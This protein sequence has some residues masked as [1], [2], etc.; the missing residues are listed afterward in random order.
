MNKLIVFLGTLLILLP[1]TA[2]AQKGSLRKACAADWKKS[3]APVKPGGGR[4]AACVK[5]H[6]GEYSDGCKTVMLKTARVVVRACKADAREMCA[7]M[8]KPAQIAECFRDHFAELSE[9][10]KNKLLPAATLGRK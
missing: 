6:Y 4:I 1:V 3:C 8:T 9:P 2:S 5:E 10:C 7:G